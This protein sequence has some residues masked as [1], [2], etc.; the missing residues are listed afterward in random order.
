MQRPDQ[1]A[2]VEP[3]RPAVRCGT[4]DHVLFDGIVIKSRVVRVLAQGAQAK[5]RCKRWVRVPLTYAERPDPR[6]I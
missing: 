3:I 5:C 4:C 2:Q 1:S 6:L